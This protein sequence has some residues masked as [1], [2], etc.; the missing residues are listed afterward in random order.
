[1][2]DLYHEYLPAD[3]LLI[4]HHDIKNKIFNVIASATIEDDN[5]NC[6]PGSHASGIL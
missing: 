2:L 6:G 5:I 3:Q 4:V 1:M